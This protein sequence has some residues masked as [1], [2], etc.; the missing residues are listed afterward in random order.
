MPDLPLLE[1]THVA[2]FRI[3]NLQVD[4]ATGLVTGPEG[5]V[6]LEPR[7]FA[8]LEALA[9][10]AGTLVTRS[11]LLA[12]IWPGADVYDEALTQ[13]VYALRQQLINVGGADCRNLISTVRKR[14]YILNAEVRPVA[15]AAEDAGASRS[16]AQGRKLVVGILAAALILVGAW[17]IFQWR[18]VT[19][20]VSALPPADTV[21]VLPF[22]PLV[23]ESRDPVLELGMADTLIARLSGIRQIVVRPISSVR[24][25]ADMDRDAVLAGNELGADAVVEGSIQRLGQSL[26]VTV[27]LLRVGDGATLW[28]DTFHD[29]SASIFAVQDAISERIAVALSQEFGQPEQQQLARLGTSDVEAYESYLK[30]RYDLARLT[31]EGM[32]SSINYFEQAVA[33]DPD[34]AQ[35]WLGLA[36]VQVR[37]A[38]AGEAPPEE[39]YLNAK[40]AALKALEIDPTLAEGH[41]MLGWIAHWYEWD[42]AASE[43]H[44]RRAIEIDPNDT[45]GHLGYAHLLSVVGRHQEALTE[46]RRAREVG[47][48][49]LIAASLEGF[50]LL[51]AQQPEEAIRRLED[52]RRLNEQFWLVRL[53][54]A[55]AYS[56]EDRVEDAL[57]E[58]RIAREHSGDGTV[59]IA[60]EITYLARLGSL[61]EAEALLAGLQQRAG[62][63][64]VP[65][66]DLALAYAGAGQSEEALAML[67]R[68]YE[69]RDPKMVLMA[70]GGWDNIRDRPE[71]KDLLQRMNLVE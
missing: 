36:N 71:F 7:V 39:Y 49:H 18:N 45:E 62:E 66:Y 50:F 60:Y 67:E 25:Y 30:G 33:R 29:S 48:F 14:G 24:R 22:L 34:Y 8:V 16:R 44:F 40:S 17:A 70:V 13:C 5:S 56:A 20:D 15:P 46:V 32:R 21:A 69:E 57:R 28:A 52:A 65:P 51:R 35:A 4:P 10:H 31:P 1:R 63:R 26:R 61:A 2:P 59:A 55:D 58:V 37:I 64:F 38:V 27:R 11:E 53:H 6:Y 68:A 42:W 19:D 43:A 41:A 47:P 12:G 3:N 23:E 54:L 9:Q